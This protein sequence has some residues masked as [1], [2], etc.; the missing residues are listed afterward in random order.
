[1]GTQSGKGSSGRKGSGHRSRKLINKI[2][3]ATSQKNYKKAANYVT[4]AALK[5]GGSSF[6]AGALIAGSIAYKFASDK[7]QHSAK[8]ISS[9]AVNAIPVDVKKKLSSDAM[10]SIESAIYTT[11]SS[12]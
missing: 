3:K 12:K 6:L 9:D 7:G 11:L 5:S 4:D 2:S 1:M 10:N 8:K